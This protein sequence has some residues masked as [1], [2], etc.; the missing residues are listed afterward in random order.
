MSHGL[1]WE[2][3]KTKAKR[4]IKP[5][6]VDFDCFDKFFITVFFFVDFSLPSDVHANSFPHH[7]RGGGGGEG[8]AG[9]R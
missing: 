8:V 1:K 3:K 5:L 6:S 2:S 7:G 4:F 9:G